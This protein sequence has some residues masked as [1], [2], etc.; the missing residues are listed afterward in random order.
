MAK[1]IQI[2]KRFDDVFKKGELFRVLDTGEIFSYESSSGGA[3]FSSH[4]T[5]ML[6]EAIPVRLPRSMRLHEVEKVDKQ[7]NVIDDFSGLRE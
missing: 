7:G 2:Y 6:M 3:N 1:A 5:V 4:V